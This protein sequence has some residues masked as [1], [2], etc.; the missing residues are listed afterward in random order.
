MLPAFS[1]NLLMEYDVPH[2]EPHT[3]LPGKIMSLEKRASGHIL[4]TGT[5]RAGTTLL[6]QL[7]TY[8]GLDT[9]YTLEQALSSID[10]ISRGGL[11]RSLRQ[12]A[13]PRIIKT[14]H[15]CHTI[16][17]VLQAGFRLEYAIIPVRDLHDAAESRRGV[18]KMASSL[19]LSK[20]PGGLWDVTDPEKQE[21]AL[22]INFYK[23]I[24]PLVRHDIPIIFLEF[25]RLAKD[26]EYL[27]KKLSLLMAEKAITLEQLQQAY[28]KLV[29]P[30]AIGRSLKYAEAD[31]K[32]EEN[33]L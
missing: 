16:D 2:P 32:P 31:A 25:P 18:S 8:L 26:P 3:S 24:E 6:M 13:L 1:G 17:E 19:G 28:E 20:A 29:Q 23:L 22:A 27:F 5:G 15:A 4:I 7:L 14:P 9:G 10:P 21:A 33:G 30:E 12:A 11:E